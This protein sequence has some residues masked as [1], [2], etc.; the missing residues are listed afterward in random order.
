M[1][2]VYILFFTNRIQSLSFCSIKFHPTICDSLPVALQQDS[3]EGKGKWHV[4]VMP[5]V[6]T[7]IGC[8]PFK[9]E[10]NMQPTKFVH[11]FIAKLVRGS[12]QLWHHRQITTPSPSDWPAMSAASDRSA[13]LVS[14]TH[15]HCGAACVAA[16]PFL[17]HFWPLGGQMPPTSGAGP[18]AV[19][20]RV[21]RVRERLRVSRATNHSGLT[22]QSFTRDITRPSRRKPKQSLGWSKKS[23]SCCE[24]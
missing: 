21:R 14:S 20:R 17:R 9:K 23:A 3:F 15:A 22:S 2:C 19:A 18:G 5:A 7:S 24:Q 6:C 1:L 10:T 4:F 13:I 12:L 16:N 11:W 8:K